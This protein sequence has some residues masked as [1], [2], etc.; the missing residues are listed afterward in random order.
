MNKR[1]N[2]STDPEVGEL[3]VGLERRLPRNNGVEVM[4]VIVSLANHD[5]ISR[6]RR[7]AIDGGAINRIG[8]IATT[9]SISLTS[10]GNK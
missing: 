4:I 2:E 10:L 3:T 9:S 5:N 8:K 7:L 1:N 6:L